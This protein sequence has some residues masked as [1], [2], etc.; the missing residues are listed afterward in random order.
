MRDI[1]SK[2]ENLWEKKGRL[3]MANMSN[4]KALS[5][6]TH[7][8]IVTAYAEFKA[9]Y[10][11][12]LSQEKEFEVAFTELKLASVKYEFLIGQA[13]QEVEEYSEGLE[14]VNKA[15]EEIETEYAGL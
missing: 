10:D 8:R 13:D 6:S 2:V 15:L 3:N 12:L 4:Y 5:S 9:R 14:Y 1:A 11:K 7:I